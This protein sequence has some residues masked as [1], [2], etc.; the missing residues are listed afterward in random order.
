MPT[1]PCQPMGE[2]GGG[3]MALCGRK[4]LEREARRR[5]MGGEGEAKG[6]FRTICEGKALCSTVV[7]LSSA[8]SWMSQG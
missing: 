8:T 4:D 1:K 6:S 3:E 2:G 7:V 5:G